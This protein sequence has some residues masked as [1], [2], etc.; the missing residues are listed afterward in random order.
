[1]FLHLTGFQTG[2]LFFGLFFGCVS[3][4]LFF[5]SGFINLV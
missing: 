3:G 5:K 1:M 2:I 4:N